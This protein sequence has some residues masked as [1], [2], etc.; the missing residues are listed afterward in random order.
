MI[1]R[2]LITLALAVPAFWL[3]MRYN[4][5]MFQL[6]VYMNGEQR[7]WIRKNFRLQWILVFAMVLG[8]L[9]MLIAF[10]PAGSVTWL[11]WAADILVWVTLAVI[12]LV[13]RVMKDM[14]QK[15][16]L[17]FTARVKRMVA[18]IIIISLIILAAVF[19]LGGLSPVSGA[20]LFITG[21]QLWM[22]MLARTVN[23]PIE[24]GV[25]NHYINDAKRI[26]RSNPDIT[27]IGVTGS[28][29]KTSVKFFLQT[30]LQQKYSVLVTPES[31]NTPMGVVITI[32]KFMKPSHEIFV[33]EMGARYVGEIKEIC[34][35]V[36]PDHG[37]ITSI[38]P[39]HLD[40]F[41][42]IENIKKTKF[43][44]AD[45]LPEDAMLFL[46]GDN[47]YIAD[48]LKQRGGD[49]GASDSG[50]AGARK[51]GGYGNVTFYYSEG[52]GEGYSAS[53][54][55]VSNLGTE[56]T[57]TAPDGETE[58]YQMKLI[59]A[60]NVI[61]VMGA[62]AVA[63]R[64]G[65]ALKDLRIPVR[66]LRPVQHRMEMKENGN[67]TIIDDAFNSNPI[68]SRAAVETL[69]LFD[70]TRI[71]ITP[72]MVE[73]GENEAEYNRKFG[74][75]AADCCDWIL[76]VGAKHTEPIREGILSKGFPEKNCLVFDKVEDAIAFAYK[77]KGQEH[78]YILLENDLPDNY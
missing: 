12:I 54:I 63:N 58:R 2:T 31:Y 32:R 42:S 68:G 51:T 15:K 4:M 69:A 14:N 67:V 48:Y 30:L 28:Y 40:T 13:Y 7:A 65:I 73:L 56:F 34:D 60:H 62:I 5:H 55:K 33:C 66:R 43:E 61:N 57:V 21:S 64:F 29:G 25:N 36:H 78:K 41:G 52:S 19:L 22:Q 70:G 18:C 3:T 50:L 26:L 76:L 17:V 59:G 11:A 49:S 27:V 39:Q 37:M 24:K 71:L 74:T 23:Q 8:I 72:G 77:I 47:E 10:S 45:A 20:L 6:N 38:G 35:I 53:D 75:Y 44:L 9:R 16:K 1:I 46:N